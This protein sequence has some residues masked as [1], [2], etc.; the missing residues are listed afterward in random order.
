M[1]TP[2]QPPAAP[3]PSPWQ[4]DPNRPKQPPAFSDWV[5]FWRELSVVGKALLGLLVLLAGIIT[6]VWFA[7]LDKL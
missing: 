7:N 2:P 4:P 5:R 6:V 1:T 3:E